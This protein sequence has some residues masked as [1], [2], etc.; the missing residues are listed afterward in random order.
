MPCEGKDGGGFPGAW[1]AIEEHVR[2]L[3][4]EKLVQAGEFTR[5]RDEMHI[6]RRQSLSQHRHCVFLSGN[7]VDRF[8]PATKTQVS[9]KYTLPPKDILFFDP[10]LSTLI[11]RL[12]NILLLVTKHPDRWA[13]VTGVTSVTRQHLVT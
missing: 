13:A 8:W 5:K 10:R 12:L 6:S 3:S 9:D 1:W 2:K 4:P 11:H 7:V